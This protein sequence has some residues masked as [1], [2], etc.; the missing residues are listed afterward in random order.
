MTAKPKTVLLVG[1]GYSGK[2]FHAPLIMAEPGLMLTAVVSS[3][4]DKVKADLPEVEVFADLG[5]ALDR[6]AFDLVVIAT[7]D[8][9]HFEGARAALESGAAAV[10]DKPF[11]TSLDEALALVVLSEAK[12]LPLFV[13]HNRRFDSDFLTLRR[14]MAEGAL[15]EV[16]L[17][18]SR[19]DRFRPIVRDRWREKP[20]AGL[21]N[22]LSPHLIDQALVLYGLPEAV[23]ADLAVL[24]QGG[25]ADDDFR[26]LL[27][28]PQMRVVLSASMLAS[29]AGMR[30]RVEGE[31]GAY[32]KHGLDVQEAQLVAGLSPQAE[33]FGQDPA[34][35]VLHRPEDDQPLA[36]PSE[37]GAYRQYYRAVAAA[38]TRSG[39]GPCS[40]S[41]ALLVMQIMALAKKSAKEA[42]VIARV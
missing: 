39:E 36:C 20:G 19:F 13:F 5:Q 21:F 10:V 32:V 15:G 12:G 8:A 37:R 16:R 33:G 38:L 34:P 18:E 42:R 41:D 11:S 1:Y 31:A 26:L 23:S 14:L 30:F 17:F 27:I 35:G 2:T 4:A 7:P 6:R 9:L 29:A 24:R 28:Y 3:H 25:Q 40:A 22:D